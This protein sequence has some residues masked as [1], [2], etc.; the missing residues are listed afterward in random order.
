ME[1]HQFDNLLTPARERLLVCLL[2]AAGCILRLAA[3]ADAPLGLNQDEASAGYE[4]YALL[5]SGMDRCGNVWPVLLESWGSG[6]NILYT[7]LTIPFV[8]VLGLNVTAVR[9]VGALF[10]CVTLGVFWHLARKL[11]GKGFGL[12]ALFLLV[13][14]PWHIMA[15]R[16]ALESNL[17]PGLLLMGIDAAVCARE[18]DFCLIGAA[19]AFG[20]AL[21][22]YG[23]A[24]FFLPIFLVG[25]A[26]LLRKELRLRSFLP[27]AALFV[28]LALPI[29]LCQLRNALGLEEAGHFLG[30]TLP[31]L[32]QSRQSATSIFGGGGLSALWENVQSLLRILWYQSDGLVFNALPLSKGGL[33]Y[34]FGLPLA[35]LGLGLSLWRGRENPGER[36]LQLSLLAALVSACCIQGNINRLNFLWLPLLYFCAVGA[37]Q[38]CVWLRGWSLIPLAGVLVCF[39]L[40][41]SSYWTTLGEDGNANFF[42]GL[43]EAISYVE[44]LEPEDIYITNAVNQ[45]YIFALFATETPPEEFLETVVY[46]DADAAFRQVESFGHFRFGPVAEAEGEY[47]ILHWSEAGGAQVVAAFGDY[48][49]CSG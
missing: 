34:F 5:V 15:S 25:A 33:Y 14:N 47:W 6:Q 12:T 36:L 32:T 2:L 16:W 22:A 13:I 31:A 8:A 44:E 42:P 30:L 17:L 43:L 46:T 11:R 24:F 4:A 39:G 7:L 9:L 21:Y 49:V 18:R 28:L 40:F 45:P 26:I 23:T 48:V 41:C 29:A 37:W 10:G 3:L 20:L 38:L 19:C 35:A 27:A 1:K